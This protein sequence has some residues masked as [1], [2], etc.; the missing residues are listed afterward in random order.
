MKTVESKPADAKHRRRLPDSIDVPR[1]YTTSVY[2]N[3]TV[4]VKIV[5]R[6]NGG[7]G[8]SH[9]GEEKYIRRHKSKDYWV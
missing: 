9:T 6:A 5:A 8:V 7:W 2:M 1:A 3:I 4:P